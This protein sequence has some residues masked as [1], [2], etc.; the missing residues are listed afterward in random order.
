MGGAP[1]PPCGAASTRAW[2]TSTL[3]APHAARCLSC[4][5]CAVTS[6][7]AWLRATIKVKKDAC[8]HLDMAWREG[9]GRRLRE[10]GDLVRDVGMP[11]KVEGQPALAV[12]G[13]GWKVSPS[14]S[15]PVLRLP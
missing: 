8:V 4:W 3:L 12:L 7:R 2:L 6:T 14:T 9:C 1:P 15:E 10:P 11:G 13:F 5:L